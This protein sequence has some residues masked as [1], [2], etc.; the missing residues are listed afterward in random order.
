MPRQFPSPKD[1]GQ[2]LLL[3]IATVWQ[4]LCSVTV[5]DTAP[6][7]LTWDT[8]GDFDREQGARCDVDHIL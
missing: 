2:G 6:W 3:G 4:L 7:S 8:L 5:S 1:A